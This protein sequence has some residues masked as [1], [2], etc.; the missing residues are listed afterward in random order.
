[1]HDCPQVGVDIGGTKLLLVA[2]HR[3]SRELHRVPTGPGTGIGFIER[4]VRAFPR[5]VRGVR[6]RC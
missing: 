1:M 5:P 6:P 2:L 4:E 3:G